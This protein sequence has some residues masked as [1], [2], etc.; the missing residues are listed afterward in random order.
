MA[1]S[2]SAGTP[3][4]RCDV[5]V[6]GGGVVG[7]AV[8]FGLARRG[9]RVT[10]LDEA[11]DAVRASRGNFGL[12]WVQGKGYGLPQYQS[13]S[14]Q[15][16]DDWGELA[17]EL[18]SFTDVDLHYRRRGGVVLCLSED[19]WAKRRDQL[20]QIRIESGNLGF[21]YEMLE[22]ADLARLL[23]GLGPKVVG[24]SYTAYDGHVNPLHLLR[25]LH[26]ALLAMGGRYLP[27][28]PVRA[29]HPAADGFTVRSG[30][31][32]VTAP[33]LVLAA[34]L[35]IPALAPFI[36]L[37]VPV[38]PQRGQNL[39]TERLAPSLPLPIQGGIRQTAE[40]GIQLGS[41]REY[42]GF[43]DRITGNGLQDVARFAAGCFPYLADVQ[44]VRAWSAFR[45]M[46]PD[47]FPIY[48][49]S[50]AFPGAFV[51][52]C[53]SGISLAAAHAYRFA[54]FVEESALPLELE[55]FSSRRFAV[56][57]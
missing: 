44:V 11:D 9:Q 25:A 57:T 13:W 45:V 55:A 6:V 51:A 35:G 16:A 33:K 43:D 47:S 46:P 7:S 26:A 14:R 5:V 24:G 41:T 19:A 53:H 38:K 36:G 1:F 18:R 29:I 10:V 23:P 32:V 37:N 22:R 20:E 34:G 3:T 48:D 8:A 54:E 49:Q 30:D 39:I 40:G 17:R 4:I 52:T 28:A 50:P 12:I 21:E 31:A 15:S 27:G 56:G 42:V 2:R